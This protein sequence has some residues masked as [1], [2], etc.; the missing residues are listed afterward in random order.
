MGYGLIIKGMDKGPKG[1]QWSLAFYMVLVINACKHKAAPTWQ[2]SY[3]STY[4]QIV[5]VTE[6][7]KK[8]FLHLVP[9]VTLESQI[10]KFF[11]FLTF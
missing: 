9:V 2:K 4:T 11:P 7:T 8:D 6:S 5:D 1:M 10:L 3:W